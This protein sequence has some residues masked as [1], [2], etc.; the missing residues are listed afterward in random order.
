V[1]AV[2]LALVSAAL[3]GATTVLVRIGLVREPEAGVAAGATL[4]PALAVAVAA[5]AVAGA[6]DVGAAWPYA[7]AGLLAPG[8]SQL[9]FTVAIRRAGASRTSVAVGAAPLV[10]VAIALVF[11]GEPAAAPLLA[12]AVLVVAGG[13]ALAAERGR[14]EHLRVS[15]LVLAGAATVLF[16]TRDNL[17]R[18]LSGDARHVRPETA[19]AAALLAGTLL[20]IV[21][22][23]RLPP[24]RVLRAFLPAGACYGAS[25]VLLFEAFFHGRIT[26]VAPLV[27]TE[28]LWGVGLSALLLRRS[29]R[30]G[31]RVALGAALV[32]AGGMLIGVV[33]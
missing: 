9:L 33:R 7:L 5:A 18:W 31:R 10:S 20:V 27:A 28:S 23:R 25:Y 24:P 3:F 12:G 30:V 6:G 8:G 11:L 1:T 26:V 16:A 32:V 15:G 29:E 2:V 4:L 14:P 17:V 13:V 22:A 21:T 19:L